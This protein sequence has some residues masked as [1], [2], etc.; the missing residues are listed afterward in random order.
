MNIYISRIK[1]YSALNSRKLWSES[2]LFDYPRR[3]LEALRLPLDTFLGLK[4]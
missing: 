2:I 4:A 1:R 3:Y